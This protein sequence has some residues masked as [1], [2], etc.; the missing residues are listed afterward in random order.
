M[1]DDLQYT[2]DQSLQRWGKNL[3]GTEEAAREV[4]RL[5][6]EAEAAKT[7]FNTTFGKI[8]TQAETEL[9][10]AHPV[11][12]DVESLHTRAVQA[13]SADAWRA[14]AAD[15]A[16]LPTLYRREHETDEDRI[17]APRRSIEAEKRADVHAASQDN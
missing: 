16:T 1:P 17:N 12:A 10:T 6:A 11:M 14:V 5:Y 15:G 13:S 9:P 3:A 8:K 2:D 7:R 4:A